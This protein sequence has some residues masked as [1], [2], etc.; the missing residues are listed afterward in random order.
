MKYSETGIDRKKIKNKQHWQKCDKKYTL[1]HSLLVTMLADLIS[2]ET[3]WPLVINLNIELPNYPT[4]QFLDICPKD[5]KTQL[6][7]RHLH[8]LFIAALKN[9]QDIQQAD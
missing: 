3:N 5:P 8:F 2:L 4:I 6:Q 1:L 9:I 7:K